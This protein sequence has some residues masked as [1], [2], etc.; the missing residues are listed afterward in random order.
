MLRS[1]RVTIGICAV[2]VVGIL[3][4]NYYSVKEMSEQ[5]QQTY[6]RMLGEGIYEYHAKTGN[7]PVRL[8]DLA[9]T[10]LAQKYPQWWT[11]EVGLAADV[12]VA[13]KDLKPDP[14]ENGQVILCYHNKG[15]DA[16]RGRMWV[17]W[18]DLRTECIPLEKLQDQLKRQ[19]DLAVPAPKKD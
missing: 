13:P 16:E 15:L 14:K 5:A 10:S 8:A 12:I 4:Y 9:N 3:A 6:L 19:D 2:L 18:G 7:W 17:C 1:N 11:E